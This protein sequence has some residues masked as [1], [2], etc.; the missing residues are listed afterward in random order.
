MSHPAVQAGEKLNVMNAQQLQIRLSLTPVA[1]R[2]ARRQ[3][4]A[5][6]AQ[7]WFERMR[8]V[9]DAAGECRP[10]APRAPKQI[11]LPILPNRSAA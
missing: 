3:R 10:V 11:V 6:Q 1:W 7:W 5:A 8:R 9:V 2:R 4:R